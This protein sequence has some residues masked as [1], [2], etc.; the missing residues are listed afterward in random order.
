MYLIRFFTNLRPQTFDI[1]K[2]AGYESSSWLLSSHRT[3][4]KTLELA[5]NIRASGA[6]LMAD[7]GTKPQ[8][9]RVLDTFKEPAGNLWKIYRR[10]RKNEGEPSMT[11][12]P[13]EVRKPAEILADKVEE[14]VDALLDDQQWSDV[15]TQQHAMNPTHIIAPEDFCIGCLTGLKVDRALSGWSID[16]YLKRNKISLKGWA[17]VANDH[18]FHNCHV[19]VTLAA[20]DY[21]TA[22]AAGRAAAERGVRNVAV[23]FAGLNNLQTATQ[24]T[25]LKSRRRL[26]RTA[27]TRYV[28]LAEILFGI[29]DGYREA[30]IRLLRFHC[31]GLGS[32]AQYY[33]LPAIFDWW[34]SISV[35]ATSPLHDAVNG[36]VLYDYMKQG[37]NTRADK[38]AKE[39]IDGNDQA[40]DSLFTR[41]S[42][43]LHG[44][45]PVAARTWW[46]EKSDQQLSMQDLLPHQ[47][48]ARALGWL[49]SGPGSSTSAV[50]RYWTGHNHW[51]CD[52]LLALIPSRKR[53]VWGVGQ[54][55]RLLTG[56]ANTIQRAAG[57]WL[58][59]LAMHDR[60]ED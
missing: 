34:T 47:P 17:M 40:Q 44:H 59:M 29:R 4:R 43:K 42:R 25:S 35:D 1:F 32:R 7:N 10:I 38:V 18:R 41:Q 60:I 54:I 19:Y 23:G 37:K 39:V 15:I 58:E 57:A 8:I 30:G 3:Y 20:V 52:A 56:Q 50:T 9:D 53:R 49:A 45:D 24:W 16:K 33:L 26:K 11:S 27:G 6:D 55:Q 22:R 28:N 2:N 36:R 48:L 51:V 5:A 46:N 31:L 14:Q 12:M 21:Y 13:A